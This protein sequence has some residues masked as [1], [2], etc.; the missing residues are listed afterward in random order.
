MQ[1]T[2][3]VITSYSIHYTKLYDAKIASDWR[4]PN[5]QFVIRPEEVD[6]FVLELPVSKLFGVGKVT[7][8]KLEQLGVH[9]CGDLRAWS[10]ARNNFV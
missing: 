6:A 1:D 8:A 5:G 10:L 7:A 3:I 2:S 4:K 9:T